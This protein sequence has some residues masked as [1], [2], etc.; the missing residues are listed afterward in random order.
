MEIL[1]QPALSIPTPLHCLTAKEDYCQQ[2]VIYQDSETRHT[3]CAKGTLYL[4]PAP[5]ALVTEHH[6]HTTVYSTSA[7]CQDSDSVALQLKIS[8]VP[9]A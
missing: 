4:V 3:P 7:L 9:E 8:V 2:C 6:R 1:F 5:N